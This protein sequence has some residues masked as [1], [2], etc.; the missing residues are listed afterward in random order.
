MNKKEAI[1]VLNLIDNLG[2]NSD[3]LRSMTDAELL[4]YRMIGRKTLSDIREI[5]GHK[6]CCS[7]C[8][9]PYEFNEKGE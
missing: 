7:N 1:R 5:L 8:G 6:K 9:L 2:K 4:K 3:E